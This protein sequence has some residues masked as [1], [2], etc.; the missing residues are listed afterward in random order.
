M[1]LVIEPIN[2]FLVLDNMLDVF[3]N[4][5]K[6][7]KGNRKEI[8]GRFS[9][10]AVMANYG[11]RRIYRVVGIDFDKTPLNTKVDGLDVTILKYYLNNYNIRIK[12]P[13]QP[14]LL[15]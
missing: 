11:N 14:L 9:N 13:K 7:K 2:K 6:Q 5:W 3:N 15:S 10:I 8:E 12:N 4:L 1:F